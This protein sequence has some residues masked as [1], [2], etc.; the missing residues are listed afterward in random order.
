[1]GNFFSELFG[2]QDEADGYEQWDEPFIWAEVP[3]GQ[4]Y[5]PNMGAFSGTVTVSGFSSGATMAND[6]SIIMSDTIKGAGMVAGATF[7]SEDIY[8]SEEDL[9]AA[10]VAA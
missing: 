5:L 1:M 8:K 2:G 7:D 4:E 9:D 6:L 10:G 3:E